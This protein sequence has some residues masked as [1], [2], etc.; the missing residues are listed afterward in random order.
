MRFLTFPGIMAEFRWPLEQDKMDVW[1]DRQEGR[2]T[3]L[4]LVTYGVAISYETAIVKRGSG[5]RG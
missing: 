2:Q 5:Q 1:T 3:K 4:W